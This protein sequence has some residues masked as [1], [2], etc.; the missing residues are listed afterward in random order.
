[1]TTLPIKKIAIQMKSPFIIA[2]LL[3]EM[4]TLL[5]GFD[6]RAQQ[7]P[8]RMLAVKNNFTRF[9]RKYVNRG[10]LWMARNK[11]YL[12]HPDANFGDRYSPEKNAV[13]LFEKR[14]I[15]SKYFINK[16][17]PSICYA[18]KSS[19]PMHFKKNGQW[20]TIDTRLNP[21]GP[22]LYEASN[23]EY[24]L[25]FDIKRKSSY[26]IT[27][28]GKTYF[29][30]WKL[31]GENGNAEKLLATANWTKYTVGDDGIAIKNIF[32]G[33][34]AEMKVFEGSI[35]TNFVMHANKFS[36]YKTLLFR[37]SFLNKHPG[38]F[39]FSNGLSG[40]GLV[41]AADFRV[42][43]VT[44]FHVKEGVMY[45]KENPSSNFQFI[46][47]YLD[48]NK[49]T[50]A[51]N[52]DF[53]NT[54]SKMGDVV[55][56]PMV[57]SMG[58]LNKNM[59]TGSHS[60]Q[61]CSLDTA[62]EYDFMVPAPPGATLLSAMFS[63]E[64]TAIAPCAGP[65]GAFSFAINGGCASQMWIGNAGGA[66]PQRFQ[67]QSILTSN[68][69]SLAGCFPSPV[70]GPGP[71]QNIPFSFYFYR[72]CH[73]PEGCDGSCI[74]ASQDLTITLVGRTFD[75]ASLSASPQNYCPGSAVTLTARG[76]YGIPPYNF[77]WP[78]LPQFNGDSVIQ[79]NPTGNMN[80]RVQI[81]DPCPGAGGQIMKSIKVNALPTPPAPAF[82]SNSPV[83][84]G[85][86]LILSAP[87]I[88]GTTYFIENPGTGLG[89]G[90]YSSTAVF[91]NVTDAYAGTWIAVAT[92][93]NG[94]TSDTSSTVVV[95]NPTFNPTVT[96]TST[97]T[98]I[99]AGTQVSFAAT[100]IDAGNS[101][102]YQWL[103]NGNKVGTNSATYSSSSLADNDA[104][105]CVLTATGPCVGKPGTSNTIV[106]N[107][108]VPTTPTFNAIGPLCQNS[109]A[110]ALP[111]ISK[112]GIAGIWSPAIINTS[113]L[114][115][116]TY[117]FTP[118][119]NCTT[120]ASLNITI[121]GSITPTFPTIAGSYC[122]NATAPALPSTSKEGI[123]G[124]W[125]PASINTSTLGTSTYIFT[126]VSGCSTPVS[127]NITI[128]AGILPT[129]DAIGPLCQN[130]T[131]PALPPTSK[132]GIAGTWSPATI[133]TSAP[134]TSTYIFTPSSV[135]NCSSPASL[136]ITIVTSI[137]ATFPTIA[138]S[139]CQN[140]KAP[141]LPSTSKE[142]INGTWSPSSIN[143]SNAGSASY[144]FTPAAGQ[145]AISSQLTIVVSPLPVL[146]MG[147]DT[148]IAAGA[149]T[150]L[151]V[152]VTGNIVTYQWTP[153]SGLS[154]PTIKDPVAS[155][156]STTVY[157]LDV[158]DDNNC[159]TSGTI[160]I[161]VAGGGSSKISV[162]N[163][164]SP[165]GDGINDTWVITGLSSFPGATVDVFNRYGQLVFHSENYN[166]A[167]DGTYNG[168]PL[169][170]GTYYYIIEPRN[171]EKKM[172]GSVTIFK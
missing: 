99:C 72:K 12:R 76:Y 4:T 66:G 152:I 130:S 60:N 71:P 157:T 33:I 26:I 135:S 63:F 16:D 75:S 140:E 158:T 172:A 151:N 136:N 65:D 127:I 15:D 102:I 11:A 154:D 37:D 170:V 24:P 59:I 93:L 41:S 166:K 143:T 92:N 10:K 137:T 144:T 145:C 8:I 109:T 116:T 163:A 48:S 61:D 162:P 73:G 68:G 78:G 95:I 77:M 97:A 83:C 22:L 34:D 19:G 57:Q 80:Y 32:P 168:N 110:P 18:Q 58:M 42:S 165:N 13:E 91:N 126:P 36:S 25:G 160:K 133:N 161:T 167:W 104:V 118:I 27:P 138:A 7:G 81:S 108:T 120:P 5:N 169:P 139:Y 113:T 54:Q 2:F 47:Y 103:L 17:T 87:P 153:T 148:T 67:N 46:P 115:T 159:E 6:L 128:V 146:N 112:E 79:V 39:T 64:F 74:M 132:E 88:A 55:I 29:N 106:I 1:M 84:S 96:I 49:L 38:N 85:G 28:D 35:K 51:V 111:P 131:A 117:I 149:S 40:N 129:F 119:S 69:A 156:S 70:C 123:A 86:Q 122:Q 171:N 142:G 114:G 155:P 94:C 52:S 21:K 125:S 53:L 62:C 14:T 100:A 98:N 147:P 45:R 82:T 150:T 9:T 134:G 3:V 164:F 121:V 105:S 141:A 43:A 50:L 30:D 107:V 89:G 90:Q 31:Y 124:T 44:A 101:P 23:Q 56:D 20:I